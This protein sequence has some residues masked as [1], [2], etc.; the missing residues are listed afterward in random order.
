M[1]RVLRS[2]LRAAAVAVGTAL[3]ARVLMRLVALDT[4]GTGSF[5][6]AG[7]A[8]IVVLFV[9]SAVGAAVGRALT[10]RT[11]VLVLVVLVTSGLLWEGDVAIGLSSFA[12][13]RAQAMTGLRWVGFWALFATISG[14][15]ALTPL[16]GLRTGR[17]RV[18]PPSRTTR[19][20]VPRD[21]A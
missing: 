6:P 5:S 4:L 13:A 20:A 7:T 3:L 12:D 1:G 19:Q 21:A 16:V 10:S 11:P 17:R 8:G 2:G 18:P 9:L 15:A 14:L